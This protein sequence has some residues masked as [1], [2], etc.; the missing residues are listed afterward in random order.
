MI[1]LADKLNLIIVAKI[2]IKG[3]RRAG[4]QFVLIRR[5]AAETDVASDEIF[6]VRPRVVRCV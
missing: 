3:I 1:A 6:V 2:V 5:C 4:E